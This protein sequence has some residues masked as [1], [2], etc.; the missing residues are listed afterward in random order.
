VERALLARCYVEEAKY[1]EARALTLAI[2]K[3]LDSPKEEL[4]R[5]SDAPF[6]GNCVSVLGWV[7]KSYIAAARAEDAEQLERQILAMQNKWLGQHNPQLVES[8]DNLAATLAAQ[9]K[10]K[11]AQECFEKTLAIASWNW[12]EQGRMTTPVRSDY[13]A[14]LRGLGRVDQAE[15]ICKIQPQTVPE[16][17]AVLLY[18][19]SG[20]AVFARRSSRPLAATAEQPLKKLLSD[21][22]RINGEGSKEA[23]AVIDQL[24]TFY[25]DHQRYD[26]AEAMLQRKLDTWHEIEGR[27]PHEML[28]CMA[29][30]AEI[31]IQEH[32]VAGGKYWLSKAQSEDLST[33]PASPQTI[34]RHAKLWLELGDTSKALS[35]TR[36]AQKILEEQGVT[37]VLKY[38]ECMKECI[39][40]LFATKQIDDAKRLM[41]LLKK[42]PAIPRI[43]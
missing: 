34:L 38:R 7:V 39:D 32:D 11:E 35:L 28:V 21:T 40:L 3:D 1:P 15:A 24:V 14:F 19:T 27:S 37:G 33:F 10:N 20:R 17:N 43:D 30:L 29:D 25:R 12:G 18:G 6:P 16:P 13:A 4:Y 9:H 36:Q 22:A 42:A 5:G 26:Q 8:Y 23:I 2:L 41:E 31:K